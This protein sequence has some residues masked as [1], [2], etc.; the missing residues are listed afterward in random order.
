MTTYLTTARRLRSGR[1]DCMGESL[2]REWNARRS[3]DDSYKATEIQPTTMFVQQTTLRVVRWLAESGLCCMPADPTRAS[4]CCKACSRAGALV[5][6]HTHKF[7]GMLLFVARCAFCI[8]HV[9]VLS[10]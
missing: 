1:A 6:A 7:A 9:D 2:R 10:L 3:L 5:P 4:N 8:P